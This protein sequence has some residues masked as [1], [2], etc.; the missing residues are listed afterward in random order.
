MSDGL[1]AI[2][3]SHL[4]DFQIKNEVGFSRPEVQTSLS[5][6]VGDILFNASVARPALLN[7]GIRFFAIPRFSA[8][9][10][11]AEK[12]Y[13]NQKKQNGIS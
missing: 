11:S 9:R 1:Q 2:H 4:R 12:L 8:Q 13:W 3:D 7:I 5:R 6:R 10:Q